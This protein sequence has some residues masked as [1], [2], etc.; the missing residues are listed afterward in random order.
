MILIRESKVIA[1]VKRDQ[2]FFTL[3]LA[4]SD[5]VI[6]MSSKYATIAV[7]GQGYTTYLVSKIK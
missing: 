7:I 4:L 2:N 3:D 6:L 5:Q 1:H